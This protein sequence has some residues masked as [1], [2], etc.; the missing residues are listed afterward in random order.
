MSK[1]RERK[2]MDHGSDFLEGDSRR[3]STASRFSDWGAPMAL[4]MLSDW[5]E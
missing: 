1:E 4:L 3:R 2:M 5:D